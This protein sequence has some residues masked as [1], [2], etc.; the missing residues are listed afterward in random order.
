MLDVLKEV[1][2]DGFN[3]LKKNLI[4]SYILVFIFL[5]FLLASL[6]MSINSALS[7][8]SIL[9]IFFIALPLFFSAMVSIYGLRKNIDGLKWKNI[10]HYFGSYFKVPYR[11]ALRVISS[12]GIFILLFLVLT[13]V[14]STVGYN[15]TTAIY[16]NFPKIVEELSTFINGTNIDLNSFMTKYN[17]E[18]STFLYASMAPCVIV[19]LSIAILYSLYNCYYTYFLINFPVANYSAG[20]M[21]YRSGAMQ[22]RK[23]MFKGYLA[24]VWPLILLFIGGYTLSIVIM[25]SYAID[26]F[27]AN[28]F[29][30]MIASA[31]A[32]LYLPFFFS[33]NESLFIANKD[34][35]DP[36]KN[37]SA[38]KIIE[39][40]SQQIKM[41][42]SYVD[43]LNKA[44]EEYEKQMSIRNETKN[45]EEDNK[46]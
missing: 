5:A 33:F 13:M 20:R 27:M 29:A 7:S 41:Q 26:F 25:H 45:D 43:Q 6:A 14:W 40:L 11:G 37:H 38:Q 18:I 15:I 35:Y 1:I 4:P 3:K 34:F 21:C 9:C 16:P 23:Y 22:A 46:E 2:K 32:S 19:S 39:S 31:L 17:L 10:F 42:Q 44:K 12:T 8:I 28:V 36:E 30:L 24:I